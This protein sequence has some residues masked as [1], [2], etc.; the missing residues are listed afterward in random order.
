MIRCW[1]FTPA[2]ARRLGAVRMM[3]GAYTLRYLVMRWRLISRTAAGPRRNFRPVGVARLLRRPLP[4]NAV[5]T[6]TIVNYGA[7]AAFTAGWR[8]RTTGPLH[9][10]LTLWTLTYR[11]SWS[12]VFHNDNLVVLHGAIVGVSPSA[13]AVSLD[14]RRLA[15]PP[16]PSWRYGWPLQLANAVTVISYALAAVAKL[17]G[18]LGLRWASG[19]SLRDQVAVD[20]IRKSAL[21]CSGD[22]LSPAVVLIERRPELW[23]LLATGSLLLELGAPLALVDRRLGRA[24]SVAAWSMHVGIK[25]IMRITFR[26]QLSG[27]TYAPFFD[28]ERL[29]PPIAARPMPAMGAAA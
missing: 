23:R 17:R 29:L 15:S 27:I 5:K 2:P 4:I 3:L 16:S 20:G 18:P 28:L 26:Y 6:L 24:W 8:H 21:V 25:A 11:N 1:F 22:G 19:S 10:L 7:T 14:A 9:A 12:M 13:D